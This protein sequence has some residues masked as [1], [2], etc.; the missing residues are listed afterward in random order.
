MTGAETTLL[1]RELASLRHRI[2]DW[3]ATRWAARAEPFEPLDTRPAPTRGDVA[4][5]LVLRLAELSRAAGSAAPANAIPPRLGDHALAD[6]IG[7]LADEL[8]AAPGVEAVAIEALDAV[9]RSRSALDGTAIP[10]DVAAL[11]TQ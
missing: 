4:Y 2:Q 1:R 5:A 6:Q 7:V 10:P 9:V 11:L 3:T 8:L